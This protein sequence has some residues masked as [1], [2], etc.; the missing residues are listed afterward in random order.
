VLDRRGSA[1]PEE[2]AMFAAIAARQSTRSLYDGSAIAPEVAARLVSAA[3]IGGVEPIWITEPVQ[4]ARI[5]ELV[6]DGNTRQMAD[7]AFV[8]ELTEWIRFNPGMAARRGDGLLAASSGNPSLPEWIGPTAFALAFRPEPEN[9]KYVAHIASSAGIMVLVAP[10]D[11]PR[12]WVAAGR[13]CQALM[14]TATV[15][16]LKCAFINQATEVPE[17]RAG[18]RW[19][20][21]IGD[22]RPS[23]VLRIGRADALPY[24]PR[25]PVAEVFEGA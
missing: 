10:E 12:G 24:A 6:V 2:G 8:A 20:L 1:H 5:T 19:L 9:A 16:G 3:R 21:G 4:I 22:L 17:L 25:R 7:P 23:L 18:L 15:E 13:A 14:L 11:A